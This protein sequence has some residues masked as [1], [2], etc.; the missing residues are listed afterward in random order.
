M[1]PCG[2][3]NEASLCIK[4]KINGWGLPAGTNM[5][6]KPKDVFAQGYARGKAHTP[7]VEQLYTGE[8]LPPGYGLDW[9]TQGR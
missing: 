1:G 4:A 5:P 6:K 8:V 2:V 3:L 7:V 9:E